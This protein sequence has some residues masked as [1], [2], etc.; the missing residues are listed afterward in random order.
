MRE[1]RGFSLVEVLVALLILSF[2]IT[3]SFTA[4]VERNKRLQQASEILLVYQALANEAEY[5]RRVPFGSLDTM[6]A[7]FMSDTA[8]L[9][10]LEPYGAIV[11][12]ETT[13]PGLRDITITVR[14]HNG[15][16][17]ARLGVLRADTGGS[18][19]W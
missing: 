14:W 8:L 16:R 6:S 12:V 13:K 3:V 15:K 17:E 4:F 11:K 1:K 7:S 19:L 2:I 10:P 9:T 5:W 18:S